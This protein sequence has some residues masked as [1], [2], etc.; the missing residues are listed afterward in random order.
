ME[1]VICYE[2]TNEKTRCN[3]SL[4]LNCKTKLK[5]NECP[6]C[7]EE[8]ISSSFKIQMAF[9]H[10]VYLFGDRFKDNKYYNDL[11][12]GIDR[13]G[14]LKSDILF[15]IEETDSFDDRGIIIKIGK[16]EYLDSYSI[17]NI[18]YR[19]P[20]LDNIER[21]FQYFL[22]HKKGIILENYFDK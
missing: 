18:Y 8:L 4:C 3:H 19:V 9:S 1:C 13:K 16:Q 5:K 15:Y 11:K 7:R 6:Y 22:C 17:G 14:L 12:Q 2:E 20:G 21:N 10:F